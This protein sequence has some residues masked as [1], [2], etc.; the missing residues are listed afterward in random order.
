MI[1]INMGWEL[2]ILDLFQSHHS[3]ENVTIQCRD[4]DENR[5]VITQTL[6]FLSMDS[7]CTHRLKTSSDCWELRAGAAGSHAGSCS[8]TGTAQHVIVLGIV[9]K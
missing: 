5:E 2:G 9:R 7:R 3:D 8:L 1:A 4:Y 6:R